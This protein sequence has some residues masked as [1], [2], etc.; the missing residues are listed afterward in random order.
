MLDPTRNKGIWNSKNLPS[1]WKVTY[2]LL[3]CEVECWII[4][5]GG[6][7][8]PWNLFP[9]IV[10]LHDLYCLFWNDD[11]ETDLFASGFSLADNAFFFLPGE[12]VAYKLVLRVARLFDCKLLQNFLNY[13]FSLGV[14][15]LQHIYLFW[16]FG[17]ISFSKTFISRQLTTSRIIL[18]Y[19]NFS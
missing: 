16:V 2:F 13:L 14:L 12:N 5:S 18:S 19:I 9:S 6:P 8:L 11:K 7:L 1:H 3:P 17:L 4:C 15:L 10:L